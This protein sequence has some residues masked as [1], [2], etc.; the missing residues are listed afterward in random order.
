MRIGKTQTL[1]VIRTSEHGV[2][3][4]KKD[5]A[6]AVLL[7]KSQVPAGTKAGDELTIFLYRD[8][9][10]RPVATVKKPAAEVGAFAYLTVKSV[11]KVGAFLDWGLE[12]DLFLPYKEMEEPLK[13]GRNV[14]VFLY[15]DKSDRIAATTK[16][17]E[18]LKPAPAKSFR[19]ENPFSGAVYRVNPEV[20]VFGAVCPK[21]AALTAG[22]GYPELYFGLVP[23]S[24]VYSRFHAGDPLEGR[25][26]R[27]REDGKLDLA[28][29]KRELEAIRSDAELI[30]KKIREY[31][32]TL[33]F[34]ENV[35]PEI[36]RRE[37]GLSKNAFKK[38]LGH[39]YKERKI[40][41]GED[42]ITLGGSQ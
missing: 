31:G 42:E 27:I 25:I 2:Y 5:G 6:E 39:L 4:G 12:K 19:K 10:D 40:V 33:P 22:Q 9:E 7:P 41:I 32:G 26:I 23:P 11:T 34:S 15:T 35:S 30:L 20:G 21:A 3:L 8:S 1:T 16:L 28:L 38:A 14:M 29:R 24:E 13:S 17:Y 36:I 18:H 37:F